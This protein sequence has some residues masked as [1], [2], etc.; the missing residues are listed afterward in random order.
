MA[1][2]TSN[3]RYVQL[4][5]TGGTIAMQANV[6][7]Q[8]PVPQLDGSALLHGLPA[9]LPVAVKIDDLFNLPSDEIGPS[10][11]WKL[12]ARIQQTLAC[13]H[14]VGIVITHGT[15]TIE[16]TAWFLELTLHTD[17]PI[18][19]V[20][21]Q[22]DASHPD[23]DG[24]RN[25]LDALRFASVS[26]AVGQGVMLVANGAIHAARWVTK[27]H[28]SNVMGFSSGEAGPL[29][30]IDG[31]DAALFHTPRKRIDPIPLV[32]AYLP[33]VDIVP[34]Y[35]G[36][37]GQQVRFACESGVQGIVVQALGMGNVNHAMLQAIRDAVQRGVA[38]AIS[39]R[40]AQGR[41]RPHYGFPGGGMSLQEA[42]A[43]FCAELS[44]QKARI[45]LMLALQ[46]SSTP[47]WLSS[48]FAAQ[49]NLRA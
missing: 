36:A 41:V 7:G 45:L 25:L 20:G 15:D 11:W 43:V 35:G 34:M 2:D 12:H 37:D 8:A 38:V 5:T 17:K 6:Q 48:Y 31:P 42:G 46:H 16:E 18:I 14:V 39:T 27:A 28:T 23:S 47:T 26:I 19:L 29:G 44:P 1:R 10:Q 21:A 30:Y 33:Q 24:P 22:R 40:V 9:L 4:I 13:E 49:L 3:Q 32:S